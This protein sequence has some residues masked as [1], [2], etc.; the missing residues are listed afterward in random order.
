MKKLA[1]LL[2]L[3]LGSQGAFAQLQ[4]V[5]GTVVDQANE[6]VIGATV[7]VDGTKKGAVTD[8]D[9]NFIINDVPAG[10]KVTISYLGMKTATLAAAAQMSVTLSDDS[11]ML[12]EVVAIGYGSAKVKDLTSPIV[13]VR[14]DQLLSTPSSSPMAARQGSGR[15]C[16]EQRCAR[17]GADGARPRHGF[18]LKQQSLVRR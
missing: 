15:E 18:V 4:T 5:K 12:D 3:A 13:V 7:S 11:K 16:S 8:T 14:G 2:M 1:L 17:L 9:G 6:P 10:A